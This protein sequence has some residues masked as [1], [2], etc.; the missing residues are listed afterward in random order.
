ME[1]VLRYRGG[2]GEGRPLLMIYS[3]WSFLAPITRLRVVIVFSKVVSVRLV[4]G[5]QLL[6]RSGTTDVL[7]SLLQPHVALSRLDGPTHLIDISISFQATCLS[8]L[9]T[10]LITFWSL[11][12]T[13]HICIFGGVWAQCLLRRSCRLRSMS[14]PST[15]TRRPSLPAVRGTFMNICIIESSVTE[16]LHAF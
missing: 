3:S 13:N 16:C 12:L 4:L 14:L 6:L 9:R 1:Q 5:A 2:V 11:I 8:S 15:L 10:S 7:L